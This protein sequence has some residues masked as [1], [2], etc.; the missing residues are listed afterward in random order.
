MLALA[1]PAVAQEPA[2]PAVSLSA[3]E[4]FAFA[5]GARDSGDYA[6]AETAYLALAQ[7]PD[8]ELRTEARFRLAR[9][10]AYQMDRKRDAA[11]LYR[12]ILDDKPDAAPVRLE[13]ARVLAEL[14]DYQ[15]ARREL[16]AVQAGALPPEVAQLVRFYS[17]ALSATKRFGGSVDLAIAPS[18]N[19]NRATSSDTLGTVIGDFELSEDAQAQSGIGLSLK[20]QGYAR[21]PMSAK[22]DMLV[23]LNLAG[24][25][26][27]K[28]QYDD[29][30]LSV[31]AGPQLMSG[32]DR[33]ALSLTAGHRWYGLDPY[34]TYYGV[35]G[36]WEHPVGDRSQLRV[37]ASALREENA[38]NALQ[39]ADRY[40]AAV[41]FDRAFTNTT[42]GGVRL[43]GSRDDARDPGY[44]NTSGGGS[45]YLYREW[46]RTT[47]VA[48]AGYRRLESDA[49]LLLYPERRKDDNLDLSLS[50][51][52]RSLTVGSF[53][54]L[55]RL[56]YERN[57]ST[58]GIY[59]YD[60]FSV[61]F[62]V[63]SAF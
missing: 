12:R 59:D 11:V 17:N 27:R 44:A 38:V 7:D 13:L 5:D 14:G 8:L 48:N 36:N 6:A 16:R 50:G 47:I 20:G 45:I 33:L 55:A 42:G 61:E 1:T 30:A 9:M 31:Q 24:D 40:S 28:S 58:V 10:Y 52:F 3:A 57:W 41:S 37:D 18:T 29:I 53:A 51:T 49:R 35:S 39:D 15:G 43:F 62:G 25:L 19:I 2:A 56:R 54:P 21:L 32:R 60:R 63:V 22:A 23:R 4:L 26:Y 46:E 34:A